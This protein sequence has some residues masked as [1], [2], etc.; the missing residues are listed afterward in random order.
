MGC[1][2]A[3]YGEGAHDTLVVALKVRTRIGTR[4]GFALQRPEARVHPGGFGTRRGE[5]M[6]TIGGFTLRG[7]EAGVHPGKHAQHEAC[8]L[9]AA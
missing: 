6:G 3:K 8:R 2:R 4:G 9:A 5:F 7:L 1:L